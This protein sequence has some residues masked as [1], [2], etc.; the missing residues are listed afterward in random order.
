MPSR[1]K[2]LEVIAM[3]TEVASLGL[4]L[5]LSRLLD[6]VARRTLDLVEADGADRKSVV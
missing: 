3:Q 4:D 5:D 6:L 1:E 2:L